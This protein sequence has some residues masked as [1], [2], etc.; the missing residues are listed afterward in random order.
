MVGDDMKNGFAN[1]GLPWISMAKNQNYNFYTCENIVYNAE[2]GK[3]DE[4]L[5]KEQIC[6]VIEWTQDDFCFHVNAP[7]WFTEDDALKYCVAER[8]QVK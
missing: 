6:K 2:K 7:L 8:V 5:P 3:L 1:A 4:N